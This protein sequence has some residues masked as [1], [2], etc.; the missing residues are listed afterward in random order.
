L[1]EYGEIRS[2]LTD[3]YPEC[4]PVQKKSFSKQIDEDE[5]Q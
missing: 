3:K 5:N 2:F 1:A 4:R